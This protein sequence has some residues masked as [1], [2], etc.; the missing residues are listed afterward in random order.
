M[1]YWYKITCFTGT[2]LL[3]LLALRALLV[4]N[5]LLYQFTC[6]TGTKLLALPVQKYNT[7]EQASKST[8]DQRSRGPQQV[9]LTDEGRMRS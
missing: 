2:K 7:D 5:Y 3:A 1:L 9:P 4:Q 8:Q 6:F